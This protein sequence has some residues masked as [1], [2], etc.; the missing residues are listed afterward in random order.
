MLK[1][2]YAIVLLFMLIFSLGACDTQ[3]TG[4]LAKYKEDAKAKLTDYVEVLKIDDYSNENRA[5][6]ERIVNTGK[7]NIDRAANKT[8]VN[9]ALNA[10]LKEIHMIDYEGR[11]FVL[12][13]SV[14]KT[15]VKHGKDFVVDIRLK[16]QSGEDVEI[17]HGYTHA[18]HFSAAIP[19]FWPQIEGWRFF[20][21]L[22]DAEPGLANFDTI[23]NNNE[24]RH[25]PFKLGSFGAKMD[26]HDDFDPLPEGS[27]KLRFRAIFSLNWGAENQQEI[28]IW[29]N[30]VMLTVQ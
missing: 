1:K 16:N 23:A 12:T 24:I 27:H 30:A 17:A 26:N 25:F 10:A 19:L 8:E 6:I 20:G 21:G 28:E 2:I 3:K 11:D 4:D 5:E 22:S 18:T 13:I 29:S 14:E 9:V 7:E 15:T